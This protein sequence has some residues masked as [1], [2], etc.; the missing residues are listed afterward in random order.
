MHACL[1]PCNMH[2][3]KLVPRLVLVPV[4]NYIDTRCVR[5]HLRPAA[6]CAECCG[7]AR[8]W[9]Q[10]I[11][12]HHT[13]NDGFALDADSTASDIQGGNPGLQMSSWLRSRLPR[14][15]LRRCFVDSWL[16]VFAFGGASG[17]DCTV[18]KNNDFRSACLSCVWTNG[19][20]LVAVHTE[21]ARTFL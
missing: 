3:G 1:S 16:S 18:D 15:Q 10:E 7:T 4:H 19:L 2:A 8:I 20:E 11:R 6:A 5:I 9:R 17:I 21:I 14:R 12:P 13:D